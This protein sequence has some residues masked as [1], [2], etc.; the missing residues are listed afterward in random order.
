[1]LIKVERHG[2]E[3]DYPIAE[4]ETFMGVS[5][6]P[7]LDFA[8]S[9]IRNKLSKQIR[10]L[11]NQGR[12]SIEQVWFG[13]YYRDE[14][15]TPKIQDVVIRW[16]DESIGWGVFANRPFKP[17]DLI[18][19]YTGKL[20]QRCR[21]DTKNAY[22]FE[23]FITETIPTKY[24]IDARDQGGISRFINHSKQPNLRTALATIDHINHVILIANVPIAKGDQLLYDYGSDY[25]S[26]RTQP[27]D[28]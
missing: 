2:Q 4:F 21:G 18:G 11:K 3:I 7:Q 23:Y 5:M 24:T 8:S 10:K 27:T 26:F 13:S 16:I 28:F 1:M 14:I 9:S 17:M 20:R 25:W 22:C 6:I 15:E 12:L 19:E